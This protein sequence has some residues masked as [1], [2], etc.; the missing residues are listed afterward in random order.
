VIKYSAFLI[1]RISVK[2]LTSMQNQE[3]IEEFLKMEL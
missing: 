3:S 1:S 2:L